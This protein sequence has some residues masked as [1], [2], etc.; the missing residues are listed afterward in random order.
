MEREERPSHHHP[1][2]HRGVEGSRRASVDTAPLPQPRPPASPSG[3]GRSS[4][5]AGSLQPDFPPLLSPSRTSP[6]WASIAK[7]ATCTQREVPTASPADII[8]IYQRCVAAGIQAR[9][10]VKNISGYEE[11]C[12]LCRFPGTSAARPPTAR[13]RQRQRR[14]NRG[15]TVT[16]STSVQT[17]Q[18]IAA[19]MPRLHRPASPPPSPKTPSPT[20]P[21]PAKN[22]ENIAA[23]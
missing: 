5:H 6:T 23:N 16:R 15:K 11:V 10:S 3:V 4:W 12:L 9:F 2:P 18:I 13:R 7:G 1:S 22:R 17:E 14:R 19:Q 8:A 21:P 20:V